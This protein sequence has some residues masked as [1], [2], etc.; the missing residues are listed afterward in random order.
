MNSRA[1]AHYHQ[2]T[3][4]LFVQYLF[5]YMHYSKNISC[6]P[7]LKSCHPFVAPASPLKHNSSFVFI[8]KL[9][10]AT[11]RSGVLARLPLALT[12]EGF[13]LHQSLPPPFH[14]VSCS[15]PQMRNTE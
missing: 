7:P 12:L 14:D 4:H 3:M 8:Q 11:C 10:P 1:E 15:L 9:L 6:V 5:H 13:S 2:F